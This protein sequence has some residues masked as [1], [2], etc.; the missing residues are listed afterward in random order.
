[1]LVK[2]FTETEEKNYALFTYI[3]EINNELRIVE[4]QIDK[5][6]QQIRDYNENGVF[7]QT[8]KHE[9]LQLLEKKLADA[10]KDEEKYNVL[11]QLK[12]SRIIFYKYSYPLVCWFINFLK[13]N[14]TMIRCIKFI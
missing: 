1:M 7:F 3:N 12:R 5:T 4:D 13:L 6:R 2:K 9:E 14:E 10:K 11:V 8:E